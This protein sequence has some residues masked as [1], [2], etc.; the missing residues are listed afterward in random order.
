MRTSGVWFVSASAAALVSLLVLLPQSSRAM[1]SFAAG[2]PDDVAQDGVAMGE[3]YN[4]SNRDEAD[5]RALL[6]C[7]TNKDSAEKVHAL[8]KVIDHFDNRCLATALDP[9]AGTPGWGWAIADSATEARD[10][11]LAMCQQSAG[12]DRAPYCEITA[13]VCDHT[14]S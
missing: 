2:I 3:S 14:A 1:A 5:A 10:H 12:A 9:K 7:R 8:C 4:Y 11:A 6:G 13:S